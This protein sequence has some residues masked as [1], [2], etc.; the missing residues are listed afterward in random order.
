MPNIKT[1]HTD[2]STAKALLPKRAPD[3]S[4]GDFGRALLITGS[5]QYEG[6][7][8]LTIEA[9]LRGGA[10][11]V[12]YLSTRALR[13]RLIKD[14]PEAIY[15][16]LL[17]NISDNTERI[18]SLAE[19]HTAVLIGSGSSVSEELY[20]LI[21]DFLRR[22]G[23]PLILDADAINSLARFGDK[24]EIKRS[25]RP[26]ILTPHLLEFSR[27][28]GLPAEEI[29]ENR[30]AIAEGFAGENNCILLLKGK[31][32]VITD[33]KATYINTTGSTAL[34]KGGS[35]DV[36]SGLLVSLLAFMKEPLKAAALAAY[37]HGRAGD[38][39]EKTYSAFGVTPSDL[40]KQIAKCIRE[41]EEG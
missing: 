26:V 41:L 19:R 3:G 11:I 2:K 24:S 4:K 16:P 22:K 34:A 25:E 36:L 21:S 13:D 15:E 20:R 5:E 29:R 14:L 35:G 6:A 17:D 8:R 18:L 1:V 32:T 7:G 28:S 40:P 39:L 27:L 31:N 9:S 38:G 37:L 30:E 10:G 12:T 33:G 23:A